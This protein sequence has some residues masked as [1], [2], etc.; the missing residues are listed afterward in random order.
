MIRSALLVSLVARSTVAVSGEKAD[1]PVL[2]KEE[3][4][5]HV[6]PRRGV[7][8]FEFYRAEFGTRPAC[9]WLHLRHVAGWNGCTE[10]PAGSNLSGGAV[11]VDRGSCSFEDKARHIEAAGGSAAIIVNSVES[12]NSGRS[13]FRMPAGALLEKF[14]QKG[15][16]KTRIV[17]VLVKS[18]VG[19]VLKSYAAK[20][21]EIWLQPEFIGPVGDNRL[22]LVPV[23]A[24]AP[25]ITARFA[26][27]AEEE[28]VEVGAT[29]G[30]AAG[31]GAAA[32]P[33]S[34]QL[35]ASDLVTDSTSLEYSGLV[36]ESG[37]VT[38]EGV[39]HEWLAA[40]FGAPFGAAP[41]AVVGAT[42]ASGCT[43]LDAS[44]VAGKLVVVK[45]GECTLLDKAK[46]VEEAGGLAVFIAN[47]EAGLRRPGFANLGVDELPAIAVGMITKAFGDALLSAVATGNTVTLQPKASANPSNLWEGIDDFDAVAAWP[48]D[49][50]ERRELFETL[51]GAPFGVGA[52]S[53]VGDPERLAMVRGMYE[54]A[55][56][57]HSA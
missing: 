3:V 26:P 42:P 40:T 9:S 31:S 51:I 37:A 25:A 55:T 1:I 4:W 34:D 54:R 36:I 47:Q 45:R 35:E 5:G 11:L 38:H 30:A 14:Q 22:A 41:L 57:K 24:C 43:A 6:Y 44:A 56:R 23:G 19:A 10:A 53:F 12:S 28:E 18:D 50:G 20:G 29:G 17:A 49:D 27:P 7:A 39:V 21:I 32:A 33:G 46:M 48:T 8:G 13:M 2:A 16:P 52:D 15:T